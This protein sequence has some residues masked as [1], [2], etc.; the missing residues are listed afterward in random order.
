MSDKPDRFE[1][2]HEWVRHDGRMRLIVPPQP[3]DRRWVYHE[4]PIVWPVGAAIPIKE[5]E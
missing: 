4:R 1:D 2:E 3:P 5:P